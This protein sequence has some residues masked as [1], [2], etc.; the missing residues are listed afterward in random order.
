MKREATFKDIILFIEAW[1]LLAF[2]RLLLIFY[3]FKKIVLI[4]SKLSKKKSNNNIV[5]DNT[6]L[7]QKINIGILRGST[8]SPWRT[9]CF[10]QALAAKIMIKRRHI[11]ST[12]FFGI[13]KNDKSKLLAHAW[14]IANDFIVTGG[15]KIDQYTV[16][17]SFES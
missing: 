7:L 6:K 8:Y 1:I 10:E 17:T 13:R 11:T 2:S 14:L 12:I 15:P 16:I 4:M 5:T 3:T 9:K